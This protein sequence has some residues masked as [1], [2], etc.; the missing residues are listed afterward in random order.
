MEEEKEALSRE[1]RWKKTS[2]RN[3]QEETE[4]L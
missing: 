1:V 2:Y 4:N 3:V